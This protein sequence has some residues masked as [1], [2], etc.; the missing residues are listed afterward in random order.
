[1]AMATDVVCGMQVNEQTAKN[2]SELDGTKYYFCGAGCKRKFDAD[3]QHYLNKPRASASSAHA[4][5][6]H[7]HAAAT[8]PVLADDTNVIY[9]CPMHPEVRQ[10]GPGICPLCGMALEP[11]MASATADNSELH[12]MTQ[13]FWISAVLSLP[14]LVI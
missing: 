8:T 6:A 14:L 3:P 2:V 12:D 5:H 11:L 10:V 1:M 7:H 13:R 9:T 4:G